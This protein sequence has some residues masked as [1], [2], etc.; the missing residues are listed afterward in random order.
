MPRAAL[1]R[2]RACQQVLYA[3][4]RHLGADRL[5]TD[6][7]RV[8]RLVG[9]VNGRSG[10]AVEAILPVGQV[11][12]FDPLADEIL[13]LARA[14][15]VAL[16]L[17]RAKRRADGRTALRP[18][19]HLTVASL[20]ELR[21]SE[22]QRLRA[23][24]WFGPLPEGQR[25]VWMLLTGTAVG[26]LVPGSLVRRE[27]M[28][29]AHEATG[30]WWSETETQARMSAVIGRAERAARG[31]K[32]EH[33]GRLVDPRY[34][35]QT[36][37]IIDLLGITEAEMRACDFRQLVSPEIRREH[38]RLDEE[39]R[40]RAAGA[41]PRS[42]YEA[43]ALSRAKPWEAEGVSRAT[44]YRQRETSPCRCMVA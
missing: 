29:L 16:R 11:W 5:A 3:T 36:E 30:G 27:I 7:A 13:P 19:R 10:T 24:R 2:W 18:S 6:A 20:W 1:P 31:E 23:H 25:D 33:R 35:F 15:L 8:L 32:I 26:Y 43:D 34:R 21:L 42:T 12:D 41:T 37:T 14:E 40:R 44:W 9:T 28:T 17:E 4:L 22:L 39:R 38:R